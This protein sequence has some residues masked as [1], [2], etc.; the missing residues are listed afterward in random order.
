MSDRRNGRLTG[1]SHSDVNNP[2]F[3]DGHRQEPERGDR[4][5][6]KTAGSQW[7]K[8]QRTSESV[9]IPSTDGSTIEGCRRTRSVAIGKFKKDEI[10][11]WVRSRDASSI[12]N[13]DSK[14]MGR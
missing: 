6:W 13:G 9:G 12:R 11:E 4:R 14:N 5:R 7:T 8:P 3:A 10:D 1:E 2:S